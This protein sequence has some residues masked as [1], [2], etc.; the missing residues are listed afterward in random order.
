MYDG[1]DWAGRQPGQPF[2]MQVQ[3]HGGK[4]RGQKHNPKWNERARNEL[5]SNVD[6]ETVVL[7]PYYPRDPVLL[8]DWADYLDCCRFTDKEVGAVLNRLEAEGLL[9]ETLVLFTTDH[10]ISHARGKQFLY[11]E[12]IHVPLIVRGPGVGTGIVRDDPV[13]L[14]DMA[15][16]SLVAAGIGVP[17]WMQG[18]DVFA[19]GYVA[20]DAVFAARDRCD[21]TMERIRS[22]R[23]TRFKYIRNSHPSRPHLQPCAYKDAKSIVQTLRELHAAGTLPELSEKLLFAETRPAEEL[24]DLQSDPFEIRNLAADPAHAETLAGLRRRLAD[25]ETHT[26]DRGRVPESMEMY[27]SDMAEYLKGQSGLPLKDAEIL[28]RNIALNKAWAAEGR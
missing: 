25:W 4:H 13:E 6:P 27:D 10:G 15:A 1:N 16:I 19:S 18:R 20:R 2:F 23:T 12:G 5:G 7:P 21:E 28:R 24:Y 3:L 26:A 14:I 9:E 22:V 11:D 17:A 8:R